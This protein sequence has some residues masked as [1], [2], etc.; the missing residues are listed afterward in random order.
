MDVPK[1]RYDNSRYD[2]YYD[3]ERSFN[4]KRKRIIYY[5]TLPDIT[6]TPPNVDLRDRYNYGDRYDDRYYPYP[7]RY[8]PKVLPKSR[9][10]TDRNKDSYPLKV[11][12][13]VNV[14]EIKK[15]PERRIYSE[16][17]RNRY[18]YQDRH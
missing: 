11:S 17:D 4:P 8:H 13:D 7:D 10:D 18:G 2:N 16:V 1:D 9:Y 6:R 12:T 15:N 5:A 3:R 14:K